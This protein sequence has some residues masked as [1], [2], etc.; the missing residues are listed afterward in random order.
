MESVPGIKISGVSKKFFR[1]QNFVQAFF[2]KTE[3]AAVSVLECVDMAVAPGEIVG[4]TG[5]NG[6]GKTTLLRII[7]G[8]MLPDRGT[9][10]AGTS[11]YYVP[12]QDNSFYSRLTGRENLRFFG[13]LKGFTKN[14]IKEKIYQ[15][16]SFLEIS[17]L[18]ASLQE[19]SS[20]MKQKLSLARCLMM[21]P[22]IL[23]LDEPWRGLDPSYRDML[24]QKLWP[25]LKNENTCVIYTTHHQEESTWA[26]RVLHLNHG[27]VET[28][29]VLRAN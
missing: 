14:Q 6:A 9:V 15:L 24:F 3:R 27:I 20:G 29:E 22:R 23:L 10:R 12:T 2:K 7:A 21:S 4:L 5:A 25:R 28:E 17:F 1:N 13:M 19:F 26:D 16:E 8:L 18:D 11:L